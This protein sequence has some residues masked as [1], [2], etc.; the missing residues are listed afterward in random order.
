[1]TREMRVTGVRYPTPGRDRKRR[2]SISTTPVR[3]RSLLWL[4][5]AAAVIGG[6]WHFGTPHLRFAYAY[7]ERGAARFYERCDYVGLHSRRLVPDD[8]R[9]PL[10]TFLLPP[11]GAW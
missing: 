1:M 9:C 4:P 11:S 7:H 6:I 8:G 5:L 10:V 2:P 3:L